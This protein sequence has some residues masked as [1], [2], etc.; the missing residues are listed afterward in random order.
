M[1]N[2]SN[3]IFKI[4]IA[5]D[6][7]EN[8][9]AIRAAF[10]KLRR[11]FELILAVTGEETYAK[12]TEELPD[13]VFL[14]LILPDMNG[15]EVIKQLKLHP[16]AKN[17]PIVVMTLP[18]LLEGAMDAGADDFL[19]KPFD[20]Y[21]L[22]QRVRASV[23][24]IEFVN[25]LKSKNYELKYSIEENI[26]K[27]KTIE[28]QRK[29]M[30]DDVLYARRIQNATMPT[31]DLINQL[32]KECFIYYKPKSIVSGDF[33][34]ISEK[35]DEIVLAAADCTGHGIS[36]AILTMAG[37]AFLH[38][39]INREG[40]FNAADVLNLLRSRMMKLMQQ[41]GTEGEA[42]DGMDIA[43]CIIN[44][45][46][47]IVQYS[48]ANNPVYIVDLNKK[49]TIFKPDRMPI[50]IHSNSEVPF[51][52]FI[53]D[54]EEGSM[55]YM[56]SDGFADQ[57]GGEAEQKY[58]YKRFQEYLIGISD[59]NTKVQEYRIN[60]EFTEWKGRNEQVDDVLVL[61]VRL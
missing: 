21:E 27:I 55:L 31:P 12:C 42:A 50:G 15:C 37:M 43:I 26:G 5:D 16:V 33:Y 48:G 52:N 59:E 51:S 32:L 49:I 46:E 1:V 29:E 38:E 41:Q 8:C 36:G 61:G 54:Y 14:D 57:F 2:V 13:I 23:R 28:T 20:E 4:L 39:V 56:F 30:L 25:K 19:M 7:H 3:E 44:K 10:Y 53:F 17:I 45:K 18:E 60:K 47:K 11:R 34:W 24:L 9:D 6:R 58:R 40:F 22:E 35:N